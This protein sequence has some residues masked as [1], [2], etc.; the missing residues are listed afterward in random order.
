MLPMCTRSKMHYHE[1][2]QYADSKKA[3]GYAKL[4]SDQ[5]IF[6]TNESAKSIRYFEKD[7]KSLTSALPRSA[8]RISKRQ[9]G[10]MFGLM[11]TAFSAINAVQ[12]HNLQKQG[13][14]TNGKIAT[15]TQIQEE[16]LNHLD[17]KIFHKIKLF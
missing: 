10:L 14:M 16:H 12:I 5:N 2:N 11:G 15:L 13:E 17:I 9:L 3:E 6:V 7:L 8:S 4:I 1:D